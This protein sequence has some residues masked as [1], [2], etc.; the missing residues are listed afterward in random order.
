METGRKNFIKKNAIQCTILPGFLGLLIVL[1]SLTAAA[2]WSAGSEG[3]ARCERLAL[4]MIKGGVCACSVTQS[5]LTLCN[6]MSCSLP[7]F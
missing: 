6:P 1:H 3:S 7:G 2:P 4:V 5:Y